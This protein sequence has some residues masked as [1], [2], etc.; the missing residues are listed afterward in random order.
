MWNAGTRER[1][2]IESRIKEERK[3]KKTKG[4]ETRYLYLK[5]DYT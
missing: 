1:G 3:R 2:G 5:G 4:N